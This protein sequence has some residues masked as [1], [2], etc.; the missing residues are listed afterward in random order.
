MGV[1]RQYSGTAGR[2]ENRQEVGVFVAYVSKKE[3]AF[4]DRAL[5]LL[6]DW[7]HDAARRKEAGVPEEVS[8]AKKGKLANA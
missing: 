3:A 6:E 8:F 7:T 1:Q 4:V 2:T 5:Y